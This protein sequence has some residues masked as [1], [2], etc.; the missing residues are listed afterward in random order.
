MTASVPESRRGIDWRYV[1]PVVVGALLPIWF[2]T[3]SGLTLIEYADK[4]YLGIDVLLYRNAAIA[5]LEGTDPWAIQATGLAFAGPPTTL[6]FYLP[7]ALIPLDLATILLMGA[8]LGAGLWAVRRL[9]LPIWWIF[10]PPVFEAIIVGN[11]DVMVLALLLV[12]GPLAGIA[13]GLKVYAVIPLLAQRRWRA[14]LVAGLSA[15]ASL[16]LVPQFIA[17]SGTVATVLDSQTAGVSAWGTPILVPALIA[18]FLLRRHGAEWLVVPAIWPNTQGHY[19]AMALPA[20]GRYP[21]AAAI[22]GLNTPLAPPV[23]IMILAVQ[24]GLAARRATFEERRSAH[25]P[26]VPSLP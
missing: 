3:Y 6:L 17:S 2:A 24:R 1:R 8:G 9:R 19:G 26:T 18:L 11:P 12:E 4:N 25:G 20:I 10:F 7:T 14:L 23:G 21:I 22:I 13:A 15:V 16:P 5:V